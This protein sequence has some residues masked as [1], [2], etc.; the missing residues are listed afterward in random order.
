MFC[1]S[2]LVS[3]VSHFLNNWNKNFENLEFL[4]WMYKLSKCNKIQ[5]ITFG[6]LYQFAGENPNMESEITSV[7]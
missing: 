6:N 4:M 5:A 1:T 2:S 7:S 3:F